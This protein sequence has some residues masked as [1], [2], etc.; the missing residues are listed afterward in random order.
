MPTYRDMPNVS[1]SEIN[2]CG[3]YLATLYRILDDGD[4]ERL[5]E[6]FDRETYLRATGVVDDFRAAHQR[7]LSITSVGL[8]QFYQS[9]LGRY[10]V[11][12]QRLKR[13]P[14]II[15]KL[16]NMGNSNLAR[17][18][19]VGGTRAVVRD[20]DEQRRLCDH[21]ERRWGD[22]I[23]RHRDYVGDPKATGYR[24][25]HFVIEKSE[26]RIEIQVRTRLQQRW[27]NAIEAADS[28]FNLAL[29]D[30]R[31]PQEML[32][33]FSTSGAMLYFQDADAQPPA[34]LADQHNAATDAVVEAGYFVRRR[35]D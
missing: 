3:D 17:L 13:L 33:Y 19:D 30:G 26:R 2:R 7:P 24:A 8:R 28:R 1:K 32:D 25:R 15:R 4:D 14:R 11:V 22:R 10:P 34:E 35:R 9:Q 12:S 31:G 29:K 27:A 6:H 20:L 23:K 21:I 5:E 18:E 16:S